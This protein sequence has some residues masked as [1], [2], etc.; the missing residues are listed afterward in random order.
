MNG[1]R[2]QEMVHTAAHCR[3]QQEGVN[4]SSSHEIMMA[5]SAVLSDTS[6]A[7]ATA[8]ATMAL[9]SHPCRLAIHADETCRR[10]SVS[11]AVASRAARSD[12]ESKLRRHATPRA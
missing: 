9:M 11:R 4:G 12:E 7:S 1:T 5:A 10:S 3:Q 6:T 2:S 8:S